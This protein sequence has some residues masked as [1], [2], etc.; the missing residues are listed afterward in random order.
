MDSN[1]LLLLVGGAI[2]IIGAA[3]THRKAALLL[4]HS[5]WKGFAAIVAL[6]GAY[7]AGANFGRLE[8]VDVLFYGGVTALL[9]AVFIFALITIIGPALD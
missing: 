3:L 5:L 9:L 1:A 7:L 4:I 6:S 2:T 8:F